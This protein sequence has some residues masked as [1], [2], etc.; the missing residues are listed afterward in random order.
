K[1]QTFSTAVDN[2]SAVSIH[3]LQGERDIS[4]FN[5]SLGKFELVGIPPAQ[6]GAPRIEVMFD[7]DANGIISVSAKDLGTG[8]EQS[9][10]VESSGKLS[11]EEVSQMIKD[12]E[13]HVEDDK[14]KL[15][16]A[17]ARNNADSALYLAEKNLR[18]YA[19]RIEEPDRKEMEDAVTNLKNLLSG[20]DV[21]A[22]KSLT[23]SLVETSRKLTEKLY[24]QA[25]AKQEEETQQE[26]EEK[27]S[28]SED[29]GEN[30]K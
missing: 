3:V 22:I 9:I 10:R 28:E 24:A 14:K 29:Q 23:D 6:R 18:E 8:N 13:S 19:D 25:S 30:N 27:S 4:A 5:K 11:D 15:E 20:N 17:R 21:E 26:S 16:E 2:Q 7:I 12:A 1:S